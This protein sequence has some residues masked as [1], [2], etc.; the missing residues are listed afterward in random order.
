MEKSEGLAYTILLVGIGLL[1]FTFLNAYLFLKEGFSI[2]TSAD[3]IKS[4][5]EVLGVLVETIINVVYLGVMGWIGSIVTTRGIQLISTTK[6]SETEKK[7]KEGE[8]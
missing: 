8:L 5:G 3:L 4:F 6:K 2:I 1:G 7:P